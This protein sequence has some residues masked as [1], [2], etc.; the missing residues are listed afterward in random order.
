M[1]A[2]AVGAHSVAQVMSNS[3]AAYK[4][5][6][7]T[8]LCDKASRVAQYVKDAPAGQIYKPLVKNVLYYGALGTGGGAAIGAV[9]GLG[10]PLVIGVGAGFGGG[11]GMGYG[12][13]VTY[14][15]KQSDY[16]D[17]LNGAK[18]AQN[19]KV[20]AEVEAL[21]KRI[22]VKSIEDRDDDDDPLLCPLTRSFMEIPAV[23]PWG[24][25]FDLAHYRDFIESRG[26]NPYNAHQKM[27]MDDV[28]IDYRRQ[29]LIRDVYIRILNDQ[30]GGVHLNAEQRMCVTHLYNDIN[31][32][33][34][35]YFGR[36]LEDATAA[37]KSG[38]IS[39]QEAAQRMSR[40][41][42]MLEPVGVVVMLGASESQSA[43]A[44][45]LNTAAS[46]AGAPPPA[47]A[48]ATATA[49]ASASAGPAPATVVVDQPRVPSPAPTMTS[50]M[51]DMLRS[52]T[53]SPKAAPAKDMS[54]SLT[55]STAS[56]GSS[57]VLVSTP[58]TPKADK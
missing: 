34:Q 15:D 11:V 18:V 58:T 22:I 20:K 38:G 23:T 28:R 37:W 50:S 6:T 2:A 41:A 8:T 33:G 1:A 36:A 48:A 19:T 12:I 43:I 31:R 47:A 52:P 17:W 30:L 26:V 40:M 10:N 24:Q 27:T 5:L 9:A 42:N 57:M 3:N 44:D 14:K 7:G 53:P 54:G 56:L 16:Q 51:A 35:R 49:S 45:P 32:R 4:K 25:Y 39:M 55:L 46:S 29:G 21:I 13:Y